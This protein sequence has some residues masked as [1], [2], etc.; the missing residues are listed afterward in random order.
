MLLAVCNITHAFTYNKFFHKATKQILS[1]V[2]FQIQQGENTALIGASGCGK[3]TLAKII[4]QLQKPQNGKI[5]FHNKEVILRNLTQRQAFYKQVQILFQDPISS[6]NPRYN[7]FENLQEPLRYLLNIH[8]SNTQRQKI[9][10]IFEQLGLPQNILYHYPVMLSG[11][12]AQRVCIARMLL[13]QPQFVILD[14]TTSGLD[15]TLQ[16][17]I[18]NLFLTM[19][20]NHNTTFLFI[21]HDIKLAY[22]YCQ[23]IMLMDNGNLIETIHQNA[24]FQSALGKEFMACYDAML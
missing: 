22:K 3:S 18:W 5:L 20:Q 13:I 9:Y 8:D 15:Y 6:L 10:P 23:K 19:Q 7:V 16:Q 14:E 11:G 1:N 21:T 4:A 12:Q 17:T 2:S 24:T